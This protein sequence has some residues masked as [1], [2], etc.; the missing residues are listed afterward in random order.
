M[1]TNP[2]RRC[3]DIDDKE[4]RK[5]KKKKKINTQTE[6]LQ[7]PI[8]SEGLLTEAKRRIG[9]K[10]IEMRIAC[11]RSKDIP[12]PNIVGWIEIAT[13]DAGGD[14]TTVVTTVAAM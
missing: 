12:L 4:K 7:D 8:H 5:K 13:G 1:H 14:C 3:S 11:H 6:V 9:K 2:I 10:R